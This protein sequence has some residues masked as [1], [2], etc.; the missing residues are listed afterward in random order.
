MDREYEP[1]SDD[2][3]EVDLDA[4]EETLPPPTIDPDERVERPEVEPDERPVDEDD[5]PA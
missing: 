1:N 3:R 2:E 5:R 4:S